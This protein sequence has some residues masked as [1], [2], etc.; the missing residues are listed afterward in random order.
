MT[1]KWL[2]FAKNMHSLND[3]DVFSV[4]PTKSVGR[5]GP[6]SNEL[7]KKYYV[8]GKTN[9]SKT[10]FIDAFVNYIFDVSFE[11]KFRFKLIIPEGIQ[12][13]TNRITIYKIYRAVDT[14]IDVV[15][16]AKSLDEHS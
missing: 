15:A 12:K 2:E 1:I 3:R 4:Y 6:E 8:A 10:T 14:I 16:D 13:Q 5:N 9:Q 11:D 7:H